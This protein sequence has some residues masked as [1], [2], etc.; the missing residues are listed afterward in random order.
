[1]PFPCA[2]LFEAGCNVTYYSVS[3]EENTVSLISLFLILSHQQ[4]HSWLL[5]LVSMG[6]WLL[7]PEISKPH[8][9]NAW[10]RKLLLVHLLLSAHHFSF[11]FYN[12]SGLVPR[13]SES[14]YRERER[15]RERL[16]REEVKREKRRAHCI[17]KHHNF[18]NKNIINSKE[19]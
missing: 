18:F 3:S 7:L 17:Y 5:F 6:V 2:S 9:K 10:V 16:T 11:H 1:M 8:C 12:A 19:Q 4:I 13:L 14:K 15:E